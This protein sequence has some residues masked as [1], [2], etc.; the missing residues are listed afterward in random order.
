MGKV[1]PNVAVGGRAGDVTIATVSRTF[2]DSARIVYPGLHRR[3]EG[4]MPAISDP[5]PKESLSNQPPEP[6]AKPPR[7]RPSRLRYLLLVAVIGLIALGAWQ[8][9]LKPRQAVPAAGPVVVPTAPVTAGPIESVIRL[10]G[11]T[12]SIKF[13]NIS[14]PRTRGG[15]RRSLVLLDLMESGEM[16]KTGEVAARID[17]QGLQDHIDDVHSTV[18]ASV[19]DIKRRRAEQMIDLDNL[20]QDVD[21]AKAELDKWKLDNGA[22]EIRPEID[23]EIIK[24][25]IEEAEAAYEQKVGELDRKRTSQAAEVKI[26]ELTSERHRRHR[27]RHQVDMGRYEVNAPIDGMVV[28]Q[29]VFRNGEFAVVRNGDQVWPGR[30]FVKVMDTSKM[31]VEAKINQA[32]SN[33]FRIGQ[34]VRVGL[35][36]F[37]EASFKGKIYSIGALAKGGTGQYVREIPVH[38]HIEGADPRLIPDLSAY[39]DVVLGREDD[40]VQVP[41]AAV[42]EEAGQPFVFVKNGTSYQKRPVELGFR[43]YTH[44]AVVSGVGVGDE[45]ALQRPAT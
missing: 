44:A 18:L 8:F 40:A 7:Q 39:A 43:N 30:L 14:A 26:L 19:S 31:K 2:I 28:R 20:R 23:R 38:I 45:V 22:A 35:D 10:A 42:F 3:S 13:V 24:L 12:S 29:M 36:A 11:V 25:A 4:A 21:I 17:G 33:L 34:E 32:E 5:S 27:N 9:L 15:E 6:V 1:Y 41:L 16:V 37:P